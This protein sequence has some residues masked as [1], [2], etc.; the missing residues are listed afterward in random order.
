MQHML[1]PLLIDQT[2]SFVVAKSSRQHDLEQKLWGCTTRVRAISV[3]H[4]LCA[5]V[6]HCKER[7]AGYVT[8]IRA[9][10]VGNGSIVRSKRRL[11]ISFRNNLSS[12]VYFSHCDMEWRMQRNLML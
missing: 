4:R 3:S 6:S 7:T 11:G 9:R 10:T 8:P 1:Q 5:G 12:S 2:A